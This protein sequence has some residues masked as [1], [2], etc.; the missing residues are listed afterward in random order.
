[1]INVSI[2]LTHILPQ[3]IVY[4]NNEPMWYCRERERKATLHFSNDTHLSVNI[5]INGQGRFHLLFHIKPSLF[6]RASSEKCQS[7]LL[8]MALCPQMLY[9]SSEPTHS[10]FSHKK[11]KTF[12][13]SRIFFH[14]Y[15]ASIRVRLEDVIICYVQHES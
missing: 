13:S 4:N 3:N 15:M 7:S 9:G 10:L 1:M 12:S 11:K 14:I 8:I 2:D 6:A 5:W